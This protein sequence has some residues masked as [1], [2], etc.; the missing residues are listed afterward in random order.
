LTQF[1]ETL[2]E[3]TKSQMNKRLHLRVAAFL[4]IPYFLGAITNK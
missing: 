2:S 1:N 4:F 3:M